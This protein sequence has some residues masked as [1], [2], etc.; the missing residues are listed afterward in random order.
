MQFQFSGTFDWSQ[1]PS[2]EEQSNL[3][4]ILGAIQSNLTVCGANLAA[5]KYE[6][7]KDFTRDIQLN[8]KSFNLHCSQKSAGFKVEPSLARDIT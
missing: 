2:S 8:F 7:F 5:H 1:V 3:D 6:G 4:T